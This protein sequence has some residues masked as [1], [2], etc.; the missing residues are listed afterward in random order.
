MNRL[1]DGRTGPHGPGGRRRST[2]DAAGR[3]PWSVMAGLAAVALTACG[4]GGGGDDDSAQAHCD[5][6]A[7]AAALPDTTASASY[8]A[9]GAVEINGVALPAH[10][11]YEGRTA[12]RTGVDGHQYAIGF[13]VRLPEDWNGRLLF[14]GG[15]GN[16]GSLRNTVGP[17]VGAVGELQPAMAAGYAVVSTDGGHE[18]SSGADFATD[19]Q[20]R[21]DHAYHAYDVS[22]V[23]AK[24]VV[25]AQ[26]GREPDHNYFYGCSGGGRQGMMFTQRF[27]DYFDG[28]IVHAPAMRVSSGA[29]IAAMWNHIA[30]TDIA[31]IEDGAPILSQALSD[32]DLALLSNSIQSACDDLDG[33]ADGMVNNFQACHYDP[34][35]LQCA[36][37]KTD[38]CLTAGQV[39][40]LQAIFDGPADSS[41]T[42]L[43]VGQ[44]TD[45]AVDQPGWR[46]WTLGTS[47]DAT[48][49]SAY[50]AL[51]S[52]AL[53]WEFFWPS[54]PDFDILDFDFDADPLRMQ[55]ES[56]IYDTYR[57]D[58]LTAFQA[59]GGKLMFMHGLADPIFS[60]H[61]TVD[62]LE[63]LAANNGGMAATAD[64]ARL[65]AL[66]G[67]NH[68]GGGRATD[69]V[70]VLTPM[71]QW[72]EEGVAPDR[73]VAAASATHA[74][75]PN[76]TRPLCAYPAYAQY[77][78]SG[79]P[80]DEANFS[81]VVP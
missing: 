36:G 24:A 37:D 47:T 71:V 42:P 1:R 41:G 28:V 79:D 23:N 64:F 3:W 10:C 20:A 31:P 52:D 61:D 12:E 4:G 6:L 14:E 74:I 53:R 73:I 67:E 62:Y 59:H 32:T 56:S 7:S 9:A 19:P 25:K 35:V 81:C 11:I 60:A 72:V 29:T 77:N 68:C 66:P 27:P 49:N 78:G 8:A 38:R 30:L 63:R 51:M 75:F 33:L 2:A 48:P 5:D 13:R 26:Y 44:V 65:F 43:Y 39:G 57:D 58:E 45:P 15:G 80:E 18:G 54:D 69:Q 17:S 46:A 22:A 21:I 40:A 16:D 55:A 76:R 50:A 70:D 34:A